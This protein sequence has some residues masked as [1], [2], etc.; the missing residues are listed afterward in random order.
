LSCSAYERAYEA[1]PSNLALLEGTA[2][3]AVRL[4]HHTRALELLKALA[5]AKPEREDVR[6]LLAHV[7]RKLTEELARTPEPSP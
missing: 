7:Q 4:G 2:N 1:D 5:A 3:L 6:T